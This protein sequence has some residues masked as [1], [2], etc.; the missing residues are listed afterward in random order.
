VAAA[1]IPS[2]LFLRALLNYGALKSL[3]A[4]PQRESLPDCMVVIPARD[5]EA[6][7]ARAVKSLPRDTVIVVDD[8]S[9]DATAEEARKA[10]AGVL[11]APA[12]P[13]GATGKSTACDAGAAILTSRWILFTDADTWFEPEFLDSAI[14][15]AESNSLD[16]LSILLQSEPQS[17][18]EHLLA[19]Y[20]HALFYA[21]VNPRAHPIAAFSGQCLLVRREGYRFVGGH[22]ALTSHFAEDA[23]MASLAERHRMKFGLVRSGRMGHMRFHEGYAGLQLGIRRGAFRFMEVE[24]WLGATLALTAFTAALWLPMAVLLV[25]EGYAAGAAFV[26]LPMIWLAGWYRPQRIVLAP[27]AVYAILP[28]LLGAMAS[29]LTGSKTE[30]KR[31]TIS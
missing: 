6:N 17:F 5:E 20:A 27:L 28:L 24:S 13:R 15:C 14:A 29:A 1:L 19:P 31:R 18:V 7:I 23:K 4:V 3:V 30:W 9:R 2:L 16:F 22:G 10:G 21:A 26:L 25:I 8:G 11:Q 12:P